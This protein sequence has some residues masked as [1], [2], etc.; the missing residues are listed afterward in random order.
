MQQRG[1][2]RA[3]CVLSSVSDL[4]GGNPYL[5]SGGGVNPFVAQIS[6]ALF[7]L[8]LLQGMLPLPEEFRI[9]LGSFGKC[10]IARTHE[11]LDQLR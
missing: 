2:R 10:G 1:W 6:R 11:S 7:P 9:L 8:T 4:L 5:G 3:K